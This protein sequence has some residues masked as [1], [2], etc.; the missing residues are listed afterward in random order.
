M[1][2]EKVALRYSVHSFLEYE[3]LGYGLHFDST[4]SEKLDRRLSVCVLA[5]FG[6]GMWSSGASQSAPFLPYPP[7]SEAVRGVWISEAYLD[8]GP[9]GSTQETPGRTKD[10]FTALAHTGGI[11]LRAHNGDMPTKTYSAETWCIPLRFTMHWAPWRFPPE[12][13]SIFTSSRQ[14]QSSSVSPKTTSACNGGDK[15]KGGKL[16]P[17]GERSLGS[18]QGDESKR[19]ACLT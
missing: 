1:C 10:Y 6:G 19:K 8:T 2:S 13:T 16:S 18:T 5:C 3:L 11:V 15:G 12:H 7:S 4:V 14:R 9:L 17:A